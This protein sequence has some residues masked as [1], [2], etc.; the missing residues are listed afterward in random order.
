MR[1]LQAQPSSPCPGPIEAPDTSSLLASLEMPREC[2]Q[3]INLASSAAYVL[4]TCSSTSSPTASLG[5]LDL[6]S[7][8]HCL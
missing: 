6:P 5:N 7:S 2:K 4:L 8:Q 3:T 1:A